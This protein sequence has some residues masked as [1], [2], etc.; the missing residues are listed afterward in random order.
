MRLGPGSSGS[1]GL[2][3]GVTAQSFLQGRD[4]KKVTGPVTEAPDCWI[5]EFLYKCKIVCE[6]PILLEL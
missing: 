2:S 3:H 5:L 6:Y 4:E 1:A